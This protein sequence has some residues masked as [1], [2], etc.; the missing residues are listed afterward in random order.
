M[1]ITIERDRFAHVTFKNQRVEVTRAYSTRVHTCVE[2]DATD[3]VGYSEIALN[4][5]RKSYVAC[6]DFSVNNGS[7]QVFFEIEDLQ[8]LNGLVCARCEEMLEDAITLSDKRRVC[9]ACLCDGCKDA[10]MRFIDADLDDRQLCVACVK[11]VA[12]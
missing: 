4:A 6:H 10:P 9:P 8:I 5:G 3:M 2:Y 7:T 12:P 11:A 1:H